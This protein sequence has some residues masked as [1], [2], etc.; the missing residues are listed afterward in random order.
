MRPYGRRAGLVGGALMESF[1]QPPRDLTH[2]K[3]Y[4]WRL[5]WR[6]CCLIF[7]NS[8]SSSRPSRRRSHARASVM[9]FKTR[10]R[11][12]GHRSGSVSAAFPRSSAKDCCDLNILFERGDRMGAWPASADIAVRR[13]ASAVSMSW[14][15]LSVMILLLMLP[16][17]AT[18]TSAFRVSPPLACFLAGRGWEAPARGALRV[19]CSFATTACGP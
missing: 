9:S 19:R 4:P 6:S 5:G 17:C 8:I 14:R 7:A 12:C 3:N 13:D 16:S 18:P 10:A 11:Q 2:C 1:A 15:R